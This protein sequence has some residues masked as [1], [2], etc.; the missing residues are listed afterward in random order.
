MLLITKYQFGHR[1][2]IDSHGRFLC[3]G[4]LQPFRS[5]RRVDRSTYIREWVRVCKYCGLACCRECTT[6]VSS[7]GRRRV[8]VCKSCAVS[9]N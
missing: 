6:N 7:D 3:G 9:E 2:Y 4:D 8:Y 5:V 1:Y